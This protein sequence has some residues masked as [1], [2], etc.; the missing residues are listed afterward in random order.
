[1]YLKKISLTA[2]FLF[3]LPLTLRA[4]SVADSFRPEQFDVTLAKDSLFTENIITVGA[5][6]RIFILTNDNKKVIPGDYVTF[7][8]MEGKM[9]ARAIVVK[10]RDD[11][12][13]ARIKRIYDSTEWGKIREDTDVQLLKGDDSIFQRVQEQQAE[14]Q[15]EFLSNPSDAINSDYQLL[16]QD[17]SI[18]LNQG[19]QR[20][21][22]NLG[23]IDSSNI[24]TVGV[25]RITA[26]GTDLTDKNYVN[27]QFSL[28]LQF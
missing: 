12:F 9:L 5:T 7:I 18:D 21:M 16:S 14:A 11:K 26:I 20:D 1:M 3:V 10:L 23:V 13:G 25:G 17:S 8:S 24:L 6:R 22:K 19:S 27:Y 2:L 28:F 15:N 4:Q